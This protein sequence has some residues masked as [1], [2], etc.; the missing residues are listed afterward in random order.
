MLLAAIKFI[1]LP[2]AVYLALLPV[3]LH[4]DLKMVIRIESFMPT[5]VYSVISS[6]LFDLDA[7]LSAG[8]FVVNTVLFIL[9][10]LPLLIFF[11]EYLV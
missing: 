3:H 4:P 2:A 1:V 9:I 6:I 11:R 5:A 10:V 8:L 7:K